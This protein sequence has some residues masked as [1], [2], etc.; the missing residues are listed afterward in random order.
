MA[1][2]RIR[3]LDA[4][5]GDADQRSPG[6]RVPLPRLRGR[7]V[8]ARR[9]RSRGSPVRLGRGRLQSRQ[10]TVASADDGPWPGGG[11]VWR[12]GGCATTAREGKRVP[13]SLTTVYSRGCR[14]AHSAGPRVFACVGVTGNEQLRARA[15]PAGSRPK[16]DGAL[17]DPAEPAGGWSFPRDEV[18]PAHRR[19]GP[20]RQLQ[21]VH[22]IADD[23]PLPHLGEI[24]RGAMGPSTGRRSAADRRR[25]L[26]ISGVAGGTR[27]TS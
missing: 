22:G 27:A 26:T 5:A 16:G 23:R 9:S 2:G 19:S 3:A 18:G 15:A 1:P 10:P 7:T 17:R 6:T 13:A 21:W 25:G 20:P 12:L 24:G 14:S 4:A 8:R 11:A